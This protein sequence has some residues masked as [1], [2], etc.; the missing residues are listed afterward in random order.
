MTVLSDLVQ[1]VIDM[2]GKFLDV[3]LNGPFPPSQ[4]ILILF[5]ALFVA[6]PSI[7][8]LYFTAGAGFDLLRSGVT[9]TTHPE[10]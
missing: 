10:E 9:G 2:P 8:L 4:A 1:S 3:I 5:G 6:I 7:A